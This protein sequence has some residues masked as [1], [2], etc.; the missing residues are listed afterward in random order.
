MGKGRHAATGVAQGQGKGQ[1]MDGV[2]VKWKNSRWR[3]RSSVPR[4]DDEQRPA[5]DKYRE[6]KGWHRAARV[7]KVG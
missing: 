2:K 1:V 3:K 5:L 6:P 4:Y 7:R